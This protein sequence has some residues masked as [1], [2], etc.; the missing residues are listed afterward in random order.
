MQTPANSSTG[1]D[2]IDPRKDTT[3]STLGKCY[4]CH[5]LQVFGVG[6]RPD[7]SDEQVRG[8][9]HEA[10]DDQLADGN[11]VADDP[12]QPSNHGNH[13]DPQPEQTPTQYVNDNSYPRE[14]L[15][16]RFLDRLA[17]KLSTGR[18]A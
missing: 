3:A 16:Y 18:L 1:H 15:C 11:P 6:A 2:T 12:P 13:D 8:T 4:R 14:G 7:E 10:D 5:V 17:T 9:D